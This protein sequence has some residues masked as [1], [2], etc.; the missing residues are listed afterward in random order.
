MTSPKKSTADTE[1][2]IAQNEGTTESRKIGS[3]SI[4][5]ALA[6]SNVTSK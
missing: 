3:A 5:Q 4:A 6:K 1:I 2:I